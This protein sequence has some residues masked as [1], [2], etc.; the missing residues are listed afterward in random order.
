MKVIWDALLESGTGDV[1]IP[2]TH[3]E[4]SW[5]EHLGTGQGFLLDSLV[6]GP[7][8]LGTCCILLLNPCVLSSVTFFKLVFLALCITVITSKILQQKS[9]DVPGSPRKLNQ[10][11]NQ[12]ILNALRKSFTLIQGPPGK[13]GGMA[14][15][16]A[17]FV[18]KGRLELICCFHRII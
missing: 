6:N 16:R 8:L 12:A 11:Q 4:G 1:L 9:F 15:V 14:Q 5:A 13:A 3:R 17:Y 2:R 18:L 10:S 7:R